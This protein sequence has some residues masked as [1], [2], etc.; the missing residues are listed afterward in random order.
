M[1]S[2]TLSTA[3]AP[4]L[5][6]CAVKGSRDHRA[7]PRKDHEKGLSG[8]QIVLVPLTDGPWGEQRGRRDVIFPVCSNQNR[9]SYN[10]W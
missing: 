5:C 4:L 3:A 6:F 10:S 8:L 9:V 1:V 2:L 7:V